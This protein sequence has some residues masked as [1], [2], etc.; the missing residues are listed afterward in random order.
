MPA[1]Q[2]TQ[3]EMGHLG[4]Q[5]VLLLPMRGGKCASPLVSDGGRCS[6]VRS[7]GELKV[8]DGEDGARDAHLGAVIGTYQPNGARAEK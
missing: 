5:H 6:A 3:G 4:S 1:T 2:T 7:A 8:K